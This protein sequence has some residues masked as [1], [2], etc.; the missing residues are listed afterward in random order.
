MR[1]L[2]GAVLV[3][4]GFEPGKDER[5]RLLAGWRVQEAACAACA[6]SLRDVQNVDAHPTLCEVRAYARQRG[7]PVSRKPG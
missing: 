6:Q 5:D 1:H 3:R 2:Q 7:L 4:A